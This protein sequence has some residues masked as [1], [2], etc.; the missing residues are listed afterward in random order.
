MQFFRVEITYFTNDFVSCF[1]NNIKMQKFNKN[2]TNLQSNEEISEKSKSEDR[3]VISKH[4][5]FLMTNNTVNWILK[6]IQIFCINNLL[7][8]IIEIW[9]LWKK[10][11]KSLINTKL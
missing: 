3:Q 6:Q 10:C 1:S 8:L 11:K 7:S 9:F 5:Y 2:V 4:F